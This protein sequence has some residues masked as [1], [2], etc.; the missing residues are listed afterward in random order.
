MTCAT[1]QRGRE[2]RLKETFQR[3]PPRVRVLDVVMRIEVLEHLP[4]PVKAIQGSSRLWDKMLFVRYGKTGH[5]SQEP[6]CS[7]CQVLTTSID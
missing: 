3:I 2:E 6:L 5:R 1:N 4:E 7:G